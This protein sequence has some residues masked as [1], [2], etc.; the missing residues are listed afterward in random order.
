[1]ITFPYEIPFGESYSIQVARPLTEA[2]VLERQAA[3]AI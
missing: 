2:V 3:V 1:M